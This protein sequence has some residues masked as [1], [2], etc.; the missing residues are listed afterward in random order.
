MSATVSFD[1]VYRRVKR[2]LARQGETLH[3]CR[4][5][6]RWWPD[7]GD[8]YS[9]DLYTNGISGRHLDVVAMA[10]ELNLLGQHEVVAE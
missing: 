6:S 7:L 1:A 4:R 3:K 2:A 10:R 8:F 5:E 9:A